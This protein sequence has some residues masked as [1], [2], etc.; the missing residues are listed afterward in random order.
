MNTEILDIKE[1]DPCSN[2]LVL[3]L[4]A[5]A[6]GK[7][8]LHVEFNGSWIRLSIDVDLDHEIVIPNIL[9]EDYVHTIQLLNENGELFNDTEYKLI[10]HTNY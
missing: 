8:K 4:K 9:N 5:N 1:Y 7:W 6:T 10:T 3:P 2:D